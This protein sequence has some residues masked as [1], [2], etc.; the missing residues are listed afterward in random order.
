MEISE[1]AR[2]VSPS[3]TLAIGAKV[4]QMKAE[5]IDVVDF[6]SGEPDFDTPQ[7]VKD[8]AIKA[9][10]AGMTKYTATSGILELKE[11]ICA[12]LRRDNGLEYA[13]SQIIVSN[14]AKHSIYN[15]VLALCDPGDEAIIPAPYWVSYPEMAKLA[16]GIPVFV[17]TDETTGF[18]ITPDM[19]RSAV[20][21]K[22]KI[23][24][25]NSPSNPTGAVYARSELQ[26][27]A[28]IAVDKGFY[29]ISDEVY[30]KLVY[31]G[32]EHVSIASFNERIK[33]LTVTINGLSKSHSMTGWRIGYAAAEQEIISAMTRIQD[34]STSNPVSFVQ[35]G[36][37]EALNGPQDFT[38]MMAREFNERRR[39]IVSGLN[40]I[41]GVLCPN[42][43]GA[44]YVF[45]NISALL[46]KT[47]KVR[48][49]TGSDSLAA[50]LLEEA[51]VAVIP[52]SGFGADQNIR[53]S[54]AASMENIKKGLER[55]G[56]AASKLV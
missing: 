52:G 51:K 18:K 28:G 54:Y 3:P 6:A 46:G 15:T 38:A 32:N 20:T 25:L 26:E 23:L 41:P 1:T 30:E 10:Q 5:G 4:K 56:E 42:P 2:R 50:Y 29:V 36:A 53:L 31:D 21:P 7:N 47:Y 19:L 45:P 49:I 9:I 13:P 34:N 12:K 55:I 35:K 48:S 44:F 11:A 22:T 27:I 17:R 8:A 24:I 37:V 33:K 43:G 16:D 14:G 40:A 39:V